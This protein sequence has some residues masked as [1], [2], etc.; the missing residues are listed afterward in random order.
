MNSYEA[1]QE[2]RRQR[3]L[4]RA[5]QARQEFQTTHDRAHE[6][7]SVIPFGQPILVG[8]H[9]EKRDRNYRGRI[10]DTFGKAFAA[11][12]KAKHYEDKAASVGHGGISSDD[13]DALQ[14][15][16]AKLEEMEN[17][18]AMTKA[19]NQAIRRHKTDEARAA[20]LVALGF[21]EAN[22]QT[23]I[24]PDYVGRVG[25]PA[26][27]L[28]NNNANMRRVKERIAELERAASRQTREE[29]AEGYTYRE[30]TEENRV[31]FIFDG[32]PAENIRQLLKLHGF[33]W[34]PSRGAWV[35]QITANAMYA[36]RDLKRRLAALSAEAE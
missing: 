22:A 14:K 29:E 35:R 11:L 9:S 33:K 5:E 12:D 34:S 6:M 20:A 31:M 13:P 2:A 16:R 7:A 3:Y 1:K 23:L 24:K 10:H 30:D 21:T 25:F 17:S 4:D 27:S 36:A 28:S 32:K 26:F 15:L 18:Q 8:H 19:A